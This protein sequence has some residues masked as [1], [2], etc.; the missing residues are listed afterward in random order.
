MKKHNPIVGHKTFQNVDG[1]YRH[2]PLR[3]NEA[4]T[5]FKA[6]EKSR[7]RRAK[8]MPDEKTALKAMFEAWYR[9]KELGWKEAMYCPKDGTMF[10][11]IEPG[12]TGIF[13]CWYQGEWPDGSWWINDG[14]DT[15]PSRPILFKRNDALTTASGLR[16]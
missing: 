13:E 1:S 15:Y 4:N 9:L 12:S 7:R 10:L 11:A 5:I 3:K 2:E 16:R 6:A 14:T 8:M